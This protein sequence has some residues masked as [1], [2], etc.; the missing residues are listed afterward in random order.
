MSLFSSSTASLVSIFPV[1]VGVVSTSVIIVTVVVIIVCLLIVVKYKHRKNSLG[2][3]KITLLLLLLVF[4]HCCCFSTVPIDHVYWTQSTT[5]S[6]FV[7]SHMHV[8]IYWLTSF[9]FA[10]QFFYRYVGKKY[11]KVTIRNTTILEHFVLSEFE[12]NVPIA[13][14]IC[15][16]N[17]LVQVY[18][19]VFQCTVTSCVLHHCINLYVCMYLW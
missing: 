18:M 6:R 2:E 8:Q 19:Y 1:V 15:Q 10:S 5:E 13:F 4:V 17:V 12:F 14:N 9:S 16:C 11:L 7:L 3:D